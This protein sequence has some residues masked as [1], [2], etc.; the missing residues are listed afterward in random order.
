MSKYRLA[1]GLAANDKNN[2]KPIWKNSSTPYGKI[3][4]TGDQ[5]Y[6]NLWVEHF[7]D[8]N[9]KILEIGAGNGFL[10]HNILQRNSNVDYYILDLE[11]HFKEIQHKLKDYPNV[12]FI[13]S[14]E[15]KKIFEQDWDLIV[16]THCLSETPQYYY[17]D[18]LENLSVKNCFVIDYGNASEDPVFQPTLDKWFDETFSVKQR[19]TNNKLLGGDKRD[20]PVYIGKSK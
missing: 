11:E 10:A 4:E 19:L 20:I 1:P 3:S 9:G 16:E 14:S 17:T 5:E 2:V 18:I 13:K 12:S 6:V 8:F 7:A 15:Y